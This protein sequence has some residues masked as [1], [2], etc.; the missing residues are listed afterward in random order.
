[1]N[2]SGTQQFIPNTEARHYA[3]APSSPLFERMAEGI[4]GRLAELLYARVRLLDRHE[5]VVASSAPMSA[6]YPAQ[7]TDHADTD[8]V[9][10]IPL[11][12][13]GQASVL[14]VGESLNGESVSLRLVHALAQLVVNQAH[15]PDRT[16]QQHERKNAF[17]YSLLQGMLTDDA[18]VM[19][20]A[21]ALE[22][23]LDTPRAVILI[24]AGEYVLKAGDDDRDDAQIRR[25]A[26]LVIGSVVAFFHLP[27]D[28]ICSYIGNGEIA[29]LKASNTRNLAT[30]ATAKDAAEGS[31]S[32]W[33]NL[34]ALK[35][36]GETL[37]AHLHSDISAAIG[38]GIGRYHPG[39]HG[40]ARSYQDARAA[41]SLGRCCV[42]EARVHCLDGLGTAAFVGIADD[43][44]KTEL[45]AHLLSPLDHEPELLETL[46]KFFAENCCPS[47]TARELAIHRNTLAYRMQKI[48]S[49]TG[50]D[51]RRFDEATQ[52]HLALLLRS[53]DHRA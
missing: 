29:V 48:A 20:E 7:A 12:L 34:V 38:V 15:G 26:Q 16:P 3:A 27:N 1:M 23:D 24:D 18:A 52:M 42:G 45:A 28:T 31:H 53:L 37:L 13:D 41:L 8:A 36:A 19:Q 49:L 30:W 50:L 10:R 44:T 33:A 25:R 4:V 47:S 22:L 14:V 2:R 32:T 43:R 9:L 40:I 46:K 35:R 51:P 6:G 11:H 21:A 17:I 5:V 39:V